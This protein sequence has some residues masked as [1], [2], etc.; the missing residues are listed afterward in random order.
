MTWYRMHDAEPN[1]MTEVTR[2]DAASWNAK[3]FG[4]FWTVQKFNGARR[5]ENLSRIRAWAVD[6]D[7]G[8]KEEQVA[9]LHR[10]PII[11]SAVAETK[12]GYH[13]YWYAEDARKETY[14]PLLDS[15]VAFFGADK[16]ARDLARVLRVPGFYHLKDPENPF[17]VHW[18]YGPHPERRYTERVMLRD[19]RP[20]ETEGLKKH[21]EQKRYSEAGSDDFWERVYNLDCM[22]ALERLSGTGYV[23]GE[24]YTF[25]PVA[26]GRRFNIF[27]DGKSSP[28]WIDESGRIGSPSNGGPT[29]YSWLSWFGTPP[30]ECVRIIKE[31]YPE[32]ER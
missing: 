20:A 23:G 7:E 3:G 28:C 25:R 9:R 10:S 32:L 29:V 17:L 15:M 13:A 11:P 22:D 19:F 12:S 26:G 5:I 8:T 16:N 2:E 4:I 21:R 1:G 27:V 31:L 6:L 30:R 24:K 14:R 18:V